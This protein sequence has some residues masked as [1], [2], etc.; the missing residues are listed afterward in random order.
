MCGLSIFC[1]FGK[2]I[3]Q[4]KNI[5]RH[6]R[7]QALNWPSFLWQDAT[8]VKCGLTETQRYRLTHVA[9]DLACVDLILAVTITV[10]VSYL[11]TAVI[12]VSC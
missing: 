1:T 6:T 3:P 5:F 11:S 8:A 2:K 9:W 4:K 7:S 12:F 10:T